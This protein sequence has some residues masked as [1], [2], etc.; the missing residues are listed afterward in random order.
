MAFIYKIK[1]KINEKLYIGKTERDVETRWKEHIRHKDLYLDIPLYR[2]FNKYGIENFEITVLEQCD[3]N[4]INEREKYWISYYN[5]YKDGYNCTKGGEGSLIEYEEKEID[6]IIRRYQ[7]GER[8]D[9]LCKEYH[10]KYN[11]IKKRM[12]DRG[13]IINTKAGPQKV[14]KKICAINP[15]TLKIEYIYNSISEAG[16][17]HCGK[18]KPANVAKLIG[19]YK[20]TGIV[21]HGYLWKSYEEG[22]E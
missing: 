5:T 1:N 7:Q 15:K 4:I 8:L 14:S 6:D 16:R 9:L 12:L 19:K 3:K 18:A 2:A 22:D 21:S 17:Q 10:H 13:I 11:S 20:D